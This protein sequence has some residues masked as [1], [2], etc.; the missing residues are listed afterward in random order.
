M[1]D[2]NSNK[3]FN[4]QE[5][6]ET[7]Y[8]RIETKC[9]WGS[10]AKWVNSNF[11]ELSFRVHQAS[12]I[13]VSPNTLKR[14]FGKIKT[15]SQ[16]QPQLA[17]KDAL[18]KY[19]GHENWFS[20]KKSTTPGTGTR[21]ARAFDFQEGRSCNR[22]KIKPK[23]SVRMILYIIVLLI[24]GGIWIY[25]KYILPEYQGFYFQGEQLVGSAYHSAVFH[26]D[27]SN[28]KGEVYLHYGDNQQDILDKNKNTVT[29]YYQLPGSY[30]VDFKMDG[31][32]LADTTVDLQTEGWEVYANELT[33]PEN[34]YFP[35]KTSQ[36]LAQ[37]DEIARAGIDT[38]KIFWTHYCLVEKMQAQADNFELYA[39]VRNQINIKPVRCNHARI[40]IF[41]A[42]GK[43][44]LYYVKPGCSK[45]VDLRFSEIYLQGENNDL[46]MFA[47]DLSEWR[48]IKLHVQDQKASVFLEDSL[49]YGAVYQENLGKLMGIRIS[50]TG[51]GEIDDIQLKNNENETLIE[52]F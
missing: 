7:C 1:T 46:S 4:E 26:Y 6:L 28:L 10:R 11:E 32:T 36:N 35:V 24:L 42:H 8:T 5:F 13:H 12:G 25:K 44:G 14:A 50:F 23:Q 48:N 3:T 31:E 21:T 18:A 22:R 17:T 19:L 27:A 39:R 51:Y 41:G 34:R 20:F 9:G 37:P 45:W 49:I 15:S 38:N 2:K 33:E 52:G 29:H 47:C 43:I 40:D 30:Q 16:Y